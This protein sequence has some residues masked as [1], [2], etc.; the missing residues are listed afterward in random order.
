MGE[1]Q[2]FIGYFYS[3]DNH[4]P[5]ENL[6]VHLMNA[7]ASATTN[8]DGECSIEPS[9]VVAGEAEI[10]IQMENGPVYFRISDIPPDTTTISF[11][12]L[13]DHQLQLITLRTVEFT[14]VVPGESGG[15]GTWNT[16]PRCLSCHRDLGA[17]HCGDPTWE[18]VHS[19]IFNC[20][21]DLVAPP[22]PEGEL[23][24]N[25]QSEQEH[26]KEEPA[27]NGC[28]S[29][30]GNRGGPR[31]GNKSWE[32]THSFYRCKKEKEPEKKKPNKPEKPNSKCLTCHG[33]RGGPKC[34]SSSWKA[35]H[36]SVYKCKSNT[37]KG[38]K[39]KRK[40]FDLETAIF[41]HGL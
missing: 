6:N 20:A 39:G 9:R 26:E 33:D 41:I 34:S 37:G 8:G 31:C 40:S 18:S 17:P 4:A 36:K 27:D 16:P 14:R 11:E 25:T 3:A 28:S 38:G 1:R 30:H 5:E 2:V 19:N 22:E 24:E 21:T 23:P 35:I 15:S 32:K 13:V 10:E 29:C 7:D 12:A